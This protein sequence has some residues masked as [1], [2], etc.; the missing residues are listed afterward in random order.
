MEMFGNVSKTTSAI[1]L[2]HALMTLNWERIIDLEN[3]HNSRAMAM[4]L[5]ATFNSISTISWRS[6]L[7]VVETGVPVSYSK[8]SA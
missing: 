5:N 8:P 4:M 2:L 1:V 6:V 7:L 3:C